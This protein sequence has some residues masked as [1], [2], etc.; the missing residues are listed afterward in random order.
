MK[1][2]FVQAQ[3]GNITAGDILSPIGGELISGS[4]ETVFRGL[5]TDSRTIS[6]SDIFWA[7]RGEKFDGHDFIPQALE[8]G[9][10]GILVEKDHT[11]DR[12]MIKPQAVIAVR[13]SL[14]AL[15]DLAGWWRHQHDIRVAA[16][17]GSAGKTTTKE[18]TAG[19]LS[20]SSKV[21]K[22]Q[23]NYNNLI[24]LPLT[25]FRLGEDHQKAVLEMGMNHFGEIGRLT[26]IADPDIGLITNVGRAHLEGL[27]DITGVARA[28]VEM[29]EKIS[30]EGQVILNGDDELLMK[31]AL[32][33]KRPTITFGLGP[34]NDIRAK[35]VRRLGHK[36]LS[37]ALRYHGK[38]VDLHLSAPGFQ[39]VYNALAAAS[40]ALCMDEPIDHIVEGLKRFEGIPGR[41]K[42]ARLRGGIT[43]LDDTYN[44]N[45]TSLQAA[46]DS[47]KDLVCNGGRIII[48][49]GDMLELGDETVS[50]HLDAGG[51]I[52]DLGAA[53]LTAM[54]EHAEELVR[55]ALREGFPS[56]RAVVVDSH[57]DM[58]KGIKSVTRKGDLIF[59]K[60]SR[61]MGLE[62]VVEGLKRAY[63]EEQNGQIN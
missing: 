15:G 48:G 12:M 51:M 6:G 36:G 24:G 49:L 10:S 14:K 13:D 38:K 22:T 55:G 16:I 9:A 43:L 63:K 33:F 41:F 39:N 60:G 32:P 45:P 18:M 30:R 2:P 1:G 37:F 28:K 50:A 19:I 31:T 47:L 29:V 40:I 26:E 21:L 46:M 52:A 42:M 56:D 4:S 3:W 27:G 53:Y 25:L 58:L 54:G 59:L 44:A 57:Q 62:K 61:K 7:L 8:K 5:S 34:K 23:G 11:I 17:T 35:D 20:V